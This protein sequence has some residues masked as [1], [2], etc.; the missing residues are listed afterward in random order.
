MAQQSKNHALGLIEAGGYGTAISAAD[1]ALKAANVSILRMEP[2]I[3]S[4]GSLSVTVYLGGEVAAVLAAVAAGETEGRRIGNIVSTDVIPNL[5]AGVQTGM[6][7]G[8]L[9]L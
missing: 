1:A 8:S 7:H 6:F 3:G 5:D 9:E 2:T 4:G